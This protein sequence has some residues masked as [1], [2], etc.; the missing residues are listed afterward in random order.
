[1]YT[2]PT[3]GGVCPLDNSSWPDITINDENRHQCPLSATRNGLD[4][5]TIR[6]HVDDYWIMLDDPGPDPWIV[7]G[8]TEHNWNDCTADF[9]GTNR[10]EERRVGKECRS[11]WS[12]YH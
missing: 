2:G 7:N 12:P 11:R 9:M 8:W 6:G 1:M 5:R 10:S 4:G 3:N